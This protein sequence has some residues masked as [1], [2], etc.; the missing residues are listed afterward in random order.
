MKCDL[1]SRSSGPPFLL[2]MDKG[3]IYGLP[4]GFDNSGDILFEVGR[5]LQLLSGFIS[6]HQNTSI[7]LSQNIS[8]DVCPGS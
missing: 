8:R 3:C 5:N 2:H 4:A 1:T 7:I 6:L